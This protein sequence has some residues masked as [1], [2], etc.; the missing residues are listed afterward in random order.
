MLCLTDDFGALPTSDPG[1]DL[2]G[3]GSSNFG[4]ASCIIWSILC[5]GRVGSTN[6]EDFSGAPVPSMSMILRALETPCWSVPPDWVFSSVLE[7]FGSVSWLLRVES[8]FL[9]PSTV[10]SSRRTTVPSGSISLTKKS[11]Y[12]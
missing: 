12:L 7:S 9:E 1:S 8:L 3:S 11:V 4:A 5:R 10:E 2:I 6:A